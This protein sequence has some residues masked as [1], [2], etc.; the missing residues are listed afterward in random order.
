LLF[1]IK[2]GIVFPETD[3]LKQKAMELQNNPPLRDVS[4]QSPASFKDPDE[5]NLLEYAYV[6][7]KKK[8]WIIG[9]TVLKNIAIS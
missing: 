2:T 5:I 6:L 4:Q 8:W 7:V 1:I 3:N 9:L